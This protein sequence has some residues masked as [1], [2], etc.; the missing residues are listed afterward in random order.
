[1]AEK[2]KEL[3][4]VV[5]DE[6]AVARLIGNTLDNFGYRYDVFTSGVSSCAI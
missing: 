3:I 2:Q 5:E 6:P 4:H 1:M